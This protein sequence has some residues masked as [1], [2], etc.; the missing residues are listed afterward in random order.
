MPIGIRRLAAA[1]ERMEPMDGIERDL[2]M[3][4]RLTDAPV[5]FSC[6]DISSNVPSHECTS[7]AGLRYESSGSL[8]VM[9]ARTAR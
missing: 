5:Q 3:V 6:P 2:A 4:T 1:K 9:L 8:R 7:L